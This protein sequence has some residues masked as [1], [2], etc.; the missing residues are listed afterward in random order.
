MQLGGEVYG[1]EREVEDGEKGRYD[2]VKRMS[3]R[4]KEG[5]GRNG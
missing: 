4:R 3:D 1:Y 5:P 2:E